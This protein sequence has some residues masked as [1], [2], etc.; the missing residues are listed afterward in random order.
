MA[1]PTGASGAKGKA[2]ADIQDL[3]APLLCSSA[4]WYEKYVWTT[5][6]PL[7]VTYGVLSS[8]SIYGGSVVIAFRFAATTTA[9]WAAPLSTTP[10]YS[11]YVRWEFGVSLLERRKFEIFAIRFFFAPE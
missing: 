2:G 6:F 8:E 4:Q 1:Q 9:A 3:E 11:L 7:L 5:S 10:D